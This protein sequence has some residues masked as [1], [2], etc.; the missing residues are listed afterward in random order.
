MHKTSWHEK[1]VK[2]LLFVS[3]HHIVK[4]FFNRSSYNAVDDVIHNV[5]IQ[6]NFENVI[7]RAIEITKT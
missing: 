5:F 4:H 3:Y 7:F 2:K 6:V 1:V